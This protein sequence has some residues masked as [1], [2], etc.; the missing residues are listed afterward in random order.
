MPS[1][2]FAIRQRVHDGLAVAAEPSGQLRDL[3]NE[4][5]RHGSRVLKRTTIDTSASPGAPCPA[6]HVDRLGSHG[7]L[8]ED[9]L[10]VLHQSLP[11]VLLQR[12]ELAPGSDPMT[13]QGVQSVH[14]ID[15][16]PQMQTG[17]VICGWIDLGHAECDPVLRV[18]HS[19]RS[20]RLG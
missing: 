15:H 7:R 16:V 19:D 5:V 1:S 20:D 3:L 4:G 8:L 13:Q 17:H 11:T 10:S 6:G 14:V 12:P 9:G 2:D 18:A